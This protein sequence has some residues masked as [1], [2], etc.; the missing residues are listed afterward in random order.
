MG[1]IRLKRSFFGL[2]LIVAIGFCFPTCAFSETVSLP[3]TLDYPLLRSLTIYSAFSDPGHTAVLFDEYD[4]CTNITISEPKFSKSDSLI[5]FEIKVSIRTGAFFGDECLMPVAWEGYLA[6]YQKPKIDN[7]KWLLSFETVDSFIYDKDHQPAK[8]TGIIWNFVKF[9]IY[10]YLNSI[11]IDLSPPI[12]DVKSCLMPMFATEVRHNTQKMLDSMRPG[13]IHITHKALKIDI[14]TDVEK[15]YEEEKGIAPETISQQEL[16]NF[17]RIWETWDSFLVQMITTLP[18]EPLSDEDRRLLLDLVLETRHRF[19]AKLSEKTVGNDFIRKQFISIWRQVSPLLR[20][21]LVG[22]PSKDLWGYLAFFTA[23]DALSAL[24]KIGPTI[25]VEITRNGLIRLAHILNSESETLTYR[26]TVDEKLRRI[27]GFEPATEQ[28]DSVLEGDEIEIEIEN[29]AQDSNDSNLSK[30]F[31]SIF[32]KPVWAK[33]RK[34]NPK[35]KQIREWIVPK[36]GVNEYIKRIKGLLSNTALNV[37]Q[38]GKLPEQYHQI[39]QQIVL[40]TAWQESCFRQFRIKKKSLTYLRSYNGTSVGL[41]QVNERVWRCIYDMNHL[42]WNIK[43]NAMAGCEIIDLYFMRYVLRKIDQ[44]DPFT[45]AK[46][47]GVIYAMYNGGPGQF[48]KFLKRS[49]DQRFYESDRLF[50]E[51]YTWVINSQWDNINKCLVCS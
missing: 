8:I 34:P 40:S 2:I 39:F 51:K 9:W 10:D 44:I 3:L 42:R 49:R 20:K 19:V 43:Y 35:L 18:V 37:L 5:R 23:S 33:A 29:D 28:I 12:S 26:P 1:K 25:G 16:D 50:R 46:L 22:E 36:E 41:M 47:A 15:I 11:T 21:Y 7:K 30:V 48:K 14:L 24:D 31:F 38:K 6:L 27:F 32:C 17:I 4:G 45:E 13:K